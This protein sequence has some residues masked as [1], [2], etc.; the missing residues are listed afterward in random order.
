MEA[1]CYGVRGG[2]G[3]NG[4]SLA[5]ARGEKTVVSIVPRVWAVGKVTSLALVMFFVYVFARLP[6]GRQNL[7]LN[8]TF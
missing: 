6:Y 8:R 4:T 3:G 1:A 5:V 7:Q 2:A